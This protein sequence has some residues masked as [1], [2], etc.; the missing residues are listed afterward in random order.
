MALD[1]KDPSAMTN[2]INQKLFT[3]MMV[4]DT[5]PI[6]IFYNGQQISGLTSQNNRSIVNDPFINDQMTKIRETVITD[7][8]KAMAMYKELTKYVVDQAY[9]IPAVTGGYRTL[10]WPWLKGYSGELTVGYDDNIWPTYIWY[11]QDLKK[12]MGH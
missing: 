7:Q 11:D 9:V 1:V 12:S 5:A 4:G 8:H 6:A 2:I 10:W 3:Q